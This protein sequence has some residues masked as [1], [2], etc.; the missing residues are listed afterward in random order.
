[1]NSI[2]DFFTGLKRDFNEL[3]DLYEKIVY[4]KYPDHRK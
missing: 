3:S 1:M 2:R 4:V